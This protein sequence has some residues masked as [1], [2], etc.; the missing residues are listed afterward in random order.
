MD[1]KG[2]GLNGEKKPVIKGYDSVSV[3]L[4]KWENCRHGEQI[5][6]C[7]GFGVQGISLW[8]W[9]VILATTVG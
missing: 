9:T 7:R 8:W 3:T 1:V 6:R 4:S 5:R 2:I